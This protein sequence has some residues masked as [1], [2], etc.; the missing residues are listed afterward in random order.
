MVN[1]SAKSC[2]VL[3]IDFDIFH[4]LAPS[5]LLCSIT[6]TFI[7]KIRHFLVIHLQYKLCN[8]SGS[9]ADLFRFDDSRR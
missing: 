1:A 9:P 5:W 4:Q 3:F 6:L 7:F 2:S 8:D